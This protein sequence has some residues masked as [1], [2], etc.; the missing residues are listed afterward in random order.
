MRHVSEFAVTTRAALRAMK[1]RAP[2][3]DPIHGCGIA[4]SLERAEQINRQ[5]SH[6]IQ[7]FNKPGV[8]EP[9]QFACKQISLNCAEQK[10]TRH[11]VNIPRIS[12]RPTRSINGH[13]SRPILG[14]EFRVWFDIIFYISDKFFC[15]FFDNR[16]SFNEARLR[17]YNFTRVHSASC[18]G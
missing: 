9:L 11:I 16:L 17:Y 13:E 7:R 15:Q 14:E 18:G 2:E 12:L 4:V 10:S 5:S 8:L 1:F 3:H 6:A